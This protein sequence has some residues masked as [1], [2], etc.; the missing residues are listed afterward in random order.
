MRSLLWHLR[1]IQRRRWAAALPPILLAGA[2]VATLGSVGPAGA[3]VAGVPA[4]TPSP[5]S[6]P[7]PELTTP[8]ASASAAATPSP[9]DS[10]APSVP[11]ESPLSTPRAQSTAR[12]AAPRRA[13]PGVLLGGP[14]TVAQIAFGNGQDAYLGHT[15]GSLYVE[16]NDYEYG[17]VG[18][19]HGANSST[20]V[21]VY[22]EAQTEGPSSCQYDTHPSWGISYC[23]ANA[24][25]PEWFL[26]DRNG[27]RVQYTDN[28]YYE[29]DLGSTTYQQAWAANEIALARRDGF[30]GVDMDDVNLAPAHG[31]DGALA[32]YSDAQYEATVQAFVAVVSRELRAAGLTVSANVGNADPWDGNALAESEQMASNLSIYNHEFWLR[33]QEGT[34][35]MNGA[36]WLASIHMQESIEA[37]GTAFTALTYGSINDVTAMR[38]ARASFLLGWNGRAGSALIYR[39]DPDVVDPYSPDWTTNVGTPSGARFAVG[40]GW[41]RDFSGGTVLVNPSGSASQTFELGGTYR[42][43]DGSVVSA[44]TLGPTSGLVLP[45]V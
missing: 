13:P 16:I 43:P 8:Q 35:L 19:I 9:L 38:Y 41:R 26:L 11:S 7:T 36:E 4:D 33:W 31:T 2:V 18:A 15:G 29:M 34:P 5:S 39:P 14:S 37:T 20:K 25:H 1:A 23:F 30:N 21:L 22:A 10:S 17:R 44:V 3:P 32:K 45:G 27:Q 28:G 42:M 24:N 40:V 6:Q 12:P